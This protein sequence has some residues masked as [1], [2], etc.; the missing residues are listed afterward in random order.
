MI[1]IR[2]ILASLKNPSKRMI[3]C[4][5]ELLL[6]HPDLGVRGAEHMNHVRPGDV[7]GQ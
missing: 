1:L 7:K 5:E 3:Y 4:I 2:I 6:L